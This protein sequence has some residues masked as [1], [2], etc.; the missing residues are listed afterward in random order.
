MSRAA[1]RRG[2]LE[3]LAR[4]SAPAERPSGGRA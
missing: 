4:R 3:P 2:M 1:S